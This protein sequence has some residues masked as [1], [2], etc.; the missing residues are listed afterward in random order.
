MPSAQA[1]RSWACQADREEAG[2]R[3]SMGSVGDCC[4]NALCES[5]FATLE[6]ELL[7]PR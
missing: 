6:R 4:E 7:A 5:F 2:V 1:I 3:P